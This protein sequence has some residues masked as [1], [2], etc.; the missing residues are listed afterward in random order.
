MHRAAKIAAP[1][2]AAQAERTKPKLVSAT[3]NKRNRAMIRTLGIRRA[4]VDVIVNSHLI[5]RPLAHIGVAIA[6]PA[7]RPA[8]TIRIADQVIL[9]VLPVPAGPD[10]AHL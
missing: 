4:P 6:L 9:A 3:D 7:R 10:P 8:A 2:G 1:S 5:A